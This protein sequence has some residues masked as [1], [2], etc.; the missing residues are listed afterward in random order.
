MSL[1]SPVPVW[2]V[3]ALAGLLAGLALARL[4]RQHRARRRA[5]AGRRAE[6]D[7]FRGSHRDPLTGLANRQSFGAAL[8]AQLA[9]ATPVALIL[10]DLDGFAALNSAY[11]HRAGDEVLAAASDRLRGLIPDGR[12]LGRLGGDE[13]GVLLEMPGGLDMPCGRDA[14]EA[15]AL[16]LLRAMTEPLRAGPHALTCSVSLGAAV[17]PTHGRN[18]DALLEAAHSALEQAKQG[19]GGIWR[20][21]DPDRDRDAR[22][23]AVLKGELHAGIAAGEILP[24][25]QPIVDL[26]TGGL[27]GLEVLARWAHPA[28]G[29]LPP[30]NFIPLAEELQLTGQLTQALM[31]R[32]VADMRGWPAWLYVAF[33]VS[34]GQLRELIA[35]VRDPPVWPE[36]VLDPRRLEIE[37]TEHAMIG[38]FDVAREVVTLLQGRGTRVVLDDFGTG[39]ANFFH[40]RELPVDRVKIDRSFVRDIAHDTRAEA[41]VRAMLALGHSLGVDMVAEGIESAETASFLAG[42]GCRFGQGFLYAEPVPASRI[43]G[44][45]RSLPGTVGKLRAAG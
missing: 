7:L 20:I 5:A 1:P 3:A 2:L 9:D 31:R 12:R 43:P 29:M 18:P 4:A 22:A 10:L 19:G 23:R 8:A 27:V 24:H 34:P 32:V 11:G 42:L 45:V 37:I 15:A 40:L 25:Y 26:A 35:M 36:G 33:N 14:I 13:F 28:R 17:A 6:V 38:D 41:C 21:F 44:L 30:E 16:R 39:Q